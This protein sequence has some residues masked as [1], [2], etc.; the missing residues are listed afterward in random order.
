MNGSFQLKRKT[1]RNQNDV[2]L[3]GGTDSMNALWGSEETI[4][5]YAPLSSDVGQ[6]EVSKKKKFKVCL[7]KCIDI[8][9]LF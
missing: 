2:N 8:P 9:L 7:L 4:E 6:D 5:S 1:G 3:F